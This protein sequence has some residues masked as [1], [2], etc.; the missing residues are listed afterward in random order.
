MT[1]TVTVGNVSRPYDCIVGSGIIDTLLEKIPQVTK[2][3]RFLVVTDDNVDA[4][5]GEK[6]L[7]LLVS[8]GFD[9]VKFVFPHGEEHKN[10]STISDIL[11]F[12]AENNISR[13][14][15]IIAFGGGIVGDTAGFSAAINLRGIDFIQIPTTFL[16]MIDSSVGGKTGV[17]L[18]HGKNLAGAFYQP[19]LVLCDTD[20]LATLSEEVFRD[21]VSE[22]IKYGAIFDKSLFDKF[23][24]DFSSQISGIIGR[25]IR[26]KADVVGKD[27][28]DTGCRQ[29]LNFGHTIGHAIE[30]CSHFS[31]S[32]GH[33]VAIGMVMAARAGE[34]MGISKE[35]SAAEIAQVL[36][37]CHLPVKADIPA[38]DL[39]SVM[40]NDKKRSSDSLT[41]VL[42]E[43]IGKCILHKIPIGKLEEFINLA[44]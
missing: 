27:E 12:A 43:E 23:S 32:H 4:I 16:A 10:L 29:L 11:E 13:S 17:N 8:G 31:I 21:G 40:L 9:C 34:K 14:D 1:D 42:P 30:K 33:A 20:F 35:N 24:G 26:L 39:L 5:Y 44:V 36:S 18:K 3:K 19:R 22:A 41:L 15:C 28:F 25:C 6:I 2:A 37:I 38:S 7:S